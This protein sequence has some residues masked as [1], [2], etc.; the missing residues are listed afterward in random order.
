[1]EI[2]INAAGAKRNRL[3]EVTT[4]FLDWRNPLLRR[5]TGSAQI[6]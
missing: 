4:S 6:A 3:D 2:I 1:M 5:G